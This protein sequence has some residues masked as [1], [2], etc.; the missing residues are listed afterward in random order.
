MVSEVSG[1][2]RRL[3]RRVERYTLLWA[4]AGLVCFLARAEGHRAL[5]LTALT[6]VSI[7]SF[8]GLERLAAALNPS[9]PQLGHQ[10]K[11][12]GWRQGFSLL[13]RQFLLGGSAVAAL[14]LDRDTLPGVLVG[15]LALPAGLSTEG[16]LTLTRALRGK[17]DDD[18]DS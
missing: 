7:F 8:R 9:D 17:V 4:G 2:D 13:N 1:P 5:A 18:G 16:L 10:S 3:L 15:L 11:R 14:L 6:A 12:S